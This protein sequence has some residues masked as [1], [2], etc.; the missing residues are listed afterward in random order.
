M[1]NIIIK[2][3]TCALPFIMGSCVSMDEYPEDRLSP[4]TYFKTPVELEYYTNQFYG[5]MPQPGEFRWYEEEGELFV[6]TVLSEEVL[7]N[8]PI[9]GKASDVGWNWSM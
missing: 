2:T 7:G 3:I 9:P 5:L 4:D 8:R 1:K 6:P